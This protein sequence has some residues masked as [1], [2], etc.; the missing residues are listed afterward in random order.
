MEEII[1][2]DSDGISLCGV[3]SRPASGRC[4]L[5]IGSHGLFSDGRSPKQTALALGC[6]GRGIAFF[7]FDHRGCGKSRGDF[8]E[9]TTF[10]G[11]VRDLEAAF[12][13]LSGRKDLGPGLGL[14]G[15]S[16]GA[17]VCLAFAGRHGADAIVTN[18][19]PVWFGEILPVL[20]KSGQ[21][22]LLGKAFFEDNEIPLPWDAP[23]PIK[24]ILIF[25]G[26]RDEL[27]PLSHAHELF[28]KAR[29]PKRLIIFKGG[30]HAMSDPGHQA[31]FLRETVDFFSRGLQPGQNERKSPSSP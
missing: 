20:E 22:G 17:A 8:K 31:M 13:A 5:V 16:M 4:P 21:A 14:F 23:V 30:D 9:T 1:R 7:R 29:E 10:A 2:F 26:E 15:S 12:S 3:L 25:H 24:N 11:R 27:V 6:S 28:S 19:A 18:A